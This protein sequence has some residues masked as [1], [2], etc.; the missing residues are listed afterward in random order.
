VFDGSVFSFEG[1]QV[2]SLTSDWGITTQSINQNRVRIEG[3]GGP[4]IPED[5]SG[6]LVTVLMRVE[7]LTFASQVQRTLRIESYTGDMNDAFSPE[8]CTADFTYL[9]CSVLGDVNGDGSVTPGD[10][11]DA[12]EIFLGV[13]VP[14][15]CQQMTAD[16]NCSGDITPG[17]AQDIFEDFL[18]IIDLPACCADAQS[19]APQVSIESERSDLLPVEELHHPQSRRVF[20]LNTAGRAGDIVS[21]PILVTDPQGIS[22]FSLDMNYPSDMLEYL[23][24]KKSPMTAEFDYLTGIEEIQGLVHIMGESTLPI[25]SFHIGSLAVAVFR[26]K[27]GLPDR[28]PVLLFNADGDILNAE[29]RQGTFGRV[30]PELYEPGWVILGRAIH[31]PD[32]TLRIPVRVSG[33][34]SIKS[35]GMEFRYSDTNLHFLSIEQAEI[36]QRFMALKGYESEP[37]FLRV[38]GYGLN[39]DLGKSPGVL[40]HLVFMSHGGSGEVELIDLWDDLQGFEFRKKN[41]RIE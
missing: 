15:M 6:I 19:A 3:S 28:L 5:S 25:E 41:T 20:P 34:S 11:Q 16:A 2:G 4:V 22:H 29:I 7:C 26:V 35:F 21:I 24:I 18:G 33:V 27:Q 32:G 39:G 1:V 31:R 36:P 12:F 23:G 8:P 14:D 10:A 17:D 40:F 30:N 38:G 37:G 9:P 13:Q